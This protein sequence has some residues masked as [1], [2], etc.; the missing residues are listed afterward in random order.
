M[1]SG[2]NK[3]DNET[4]VLDKP[5]NFCKVLELDDALYGGEIKTRDNGAPFV[6]FGETVE[7]KQDRIAT[8]GLRMAKMLKALSYVME[9]HDADAP[10]N[11]AKTELGLS[12]SRSDQLPDLQALDDTASTGCVFCKVL[13]D[14]L[15]SAWETI[16]ENWGNDWNR[17]MRIKRR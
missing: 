13:R 10:T 7:T 15:G 17:I 3:L 5:C 2:S 1:L 12:C 8:S 11:V 9:D 16:R 4:I 6:D 14:D